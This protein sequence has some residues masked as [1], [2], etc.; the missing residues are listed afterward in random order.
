MAHGAIL[1][2]V[3]IVPKAPL[4]FR[5]Y[6]RPHMHDRLLSGTS[7]VFQQRRGELYELLRYRDYE[8]FDKTVFNFKL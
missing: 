5:D 4:R 8:Q 6:P 2:Q 1:P 7:G 3:P